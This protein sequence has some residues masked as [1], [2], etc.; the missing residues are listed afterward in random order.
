MREAIDYWLCEY[1]KKGFVRWCIEEKNKNIVI[2]TI[3]IFHR[4]S[5]DFFTNCA[6]LRLDLSS[7]YEKKQRIK[8]ILSLILT[9]ALSLFHCD[10][11][12]DRKSTRLNSSHANISYAVFC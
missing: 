9:P 1:T 12:A 3:E 5:D 7:D 6:L 10:K 8:D 2:G 4:T 11:I